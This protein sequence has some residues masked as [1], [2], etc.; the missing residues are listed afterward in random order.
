[1]K[2]ELVYE[3]N[4]KKL[5]LYDFLEVENSHQDL[6]IFIHGYMGYKDWGAWNILA[7][8][9]AKHGYSSAKLNLTHNGTTLESPTEFVDLEAFS[10][11]TYT[12]DLSDISSFLNT[13]ETKHNFHSFILVGHSRGG[14]LALLSGQDKHVKQIHC[15]APICSFEDRLPKGE[16]LEI[17]KKNGVFYRKNSR[18]NQDMPHSYQQYIDFQNNKEQLNILSICSQLTKKVYVY[19]GDK[20]ETVSLKNGEQIANVCPNG[21]LHIIKDANHTFGSKEPWNETHL[22]EKMQQLCDLMISN[23]KNT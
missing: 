13:L 21:T 2:K 9:W 17:W 18:T 11:A 20:D 22:P 15:L 3:G 19:H 4:N 12:G 8:C 6:I 7:K 14:A 10:S 16:N 5:G 23:F 1:M